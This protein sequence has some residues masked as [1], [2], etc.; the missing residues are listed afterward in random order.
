MT[1][2][3][4]RNSTEISGLSS[5]HLGDYDDDLLERDEPNIYNLIELELV[6]LRVTQLD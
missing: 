4:Y 1:S 3:K 2:S 6:R 5:Q